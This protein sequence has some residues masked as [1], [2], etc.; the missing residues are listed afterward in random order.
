MSERKK[1][2][3]IVSKV[4]RDSCRLD[5]KKVKVACISQGATWMQMACSKWLLKRGGLSRG[6]NGIKGT[7]RIGEVPRDL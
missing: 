4:K 6:E 5:L 7:G 3:K 2:S 1:K